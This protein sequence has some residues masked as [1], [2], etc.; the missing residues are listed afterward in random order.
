MKK[1]WTVLLVMAV[2]SLIASPARAQVP[3]GTSA[4]CTLTFAERFSPGFTLTPSSGSQSSVGSAPIYCT[5]TVQGH[6]ITGPGT[7]SNDGT[8]HNSTCLLDQN[9]GTVSLTLPTDAGPIPLDGTYKVTRVGVLLSLELELPGSRGVGSA[10][11]LP[12]KGDCV[13]NPV[14]EALVLMSV[15]LEDRPAAAV[16]TSCDLD[17]GVLRV[18]CRT[19]S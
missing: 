11:V 10:A 17:V 8:Y 5:G 13:L 18:G 7:A 1:R 3:Q 16:R 19:G 6:Q 12:T 15:N 2:A 9:E 14:T 4:V